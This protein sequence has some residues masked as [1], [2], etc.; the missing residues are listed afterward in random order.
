MLQGNT[1]KSYRQL[2]KIHHPDKSLDPRSEEAVKDLNSLYSY[3]KKVNEGESLTYSEIQDLIR[4]IGSDR[5]TGLGISLPQPE[6]NRQ[7]QQQQQQQQRRRPRVTMEDLIAM[8]ENIAK[9][10]NVKAFL[11]AYISLCDMARNVVPPIRNA[12]QRIASAK[13]SAMKFFKTIDMITGPI[14]PRTKEAFYGN[15]VDDGFFDTNA[16]IRF[17]S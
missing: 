6:V 14:D 8:A 15:M 10:Q 4:I 3:L 17:G 16:A 13:S 11:R 9:T 7:Q 12:D 5:A 2:L 1:K